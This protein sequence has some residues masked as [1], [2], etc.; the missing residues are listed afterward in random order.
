[1]SST[2][3]LLIYLLPSALLLISFVLCVFSSLITQRDKLVVYISLKGGSV[4]SFVISLLVLE[5]LLG[6]RV[7]GGATTFILVALVL[8]LFSSVVSS[9][10]SK[11][12]MFEPLYSGLDMGS[13][14]MLALSGLFLVSPSA[15]GLLI[16]LGAGLIASIIIAVALRKFNWKTDIFR[17][18]TLAFGV[19]LLGQVVMILLE[20][21]SVQTILF[22]FAS[23]F[24][25]IASVFKLFTTEEKKRN[26]YTKNIFYYLSLFLL[27]LSIYSVVF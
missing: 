26:L 8:Q 11:S 27:V 17:Y 3:N 14:L 23:I 12:N 10:P 13:S 5:N 15:Y 9:L 2:S 7:I 24:Y 4:A 18:L 20:T 22:A 16:G 25:L 21:I 6:M 1:M 19:A